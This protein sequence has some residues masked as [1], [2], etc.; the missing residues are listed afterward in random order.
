MGHVAAVSTQRSNLNPYHQGNTAMLTE[1]IVNVFSK[2]SAQTGNG[3]S[4]GG[5]TGRWC[6]SRV[7]VIL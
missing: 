6:N 2:R 3:E 1:L 7:G 4:L 5:T